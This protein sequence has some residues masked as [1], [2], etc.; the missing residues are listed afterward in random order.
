MN[1][2]RATPADAEPLS[3]L[4]ARIFTETFAADTAPDDLAAFLAKAYG[5]RQQSEEISNPD[6]VTLV[7]E[8]L[9]GLVAYAQVY[10]G[11][12]EPDCVQVEEPVELWRFYVQKDWHGGG[13]AHRLMAAVMD[14][15][16]ELGGR[17]LWLSVWERNPRAI[18]FYGKYGFRDV[19]AVDFWVGAD[20]QTDRILVAQV[21]A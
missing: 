3:R 1:I 10:R 15:A 17:H 6:V 11:G 9:E 12:R 13:I 2:R 4:A 20:C 21:P 16:R 7:A 14:A 18:A 5:V 8:A 19:G